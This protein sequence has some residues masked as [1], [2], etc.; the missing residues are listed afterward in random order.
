MNPSEMDK[1]KC[2]CDDAEQNSLEQSQL[3]SAYPLKF[4]RK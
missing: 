4:H 3:L 2:T 1:L